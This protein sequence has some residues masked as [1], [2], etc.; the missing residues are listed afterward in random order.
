VRIDVGGWRFDVA[1]GGRED[2]RTVLPLHGF[3]TNARMWDGVL[4]AAVDSAPDG[5]HA[6]D[7]PG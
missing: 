1:I 4:R 2:G 6:L 7:E 3:P 5:G